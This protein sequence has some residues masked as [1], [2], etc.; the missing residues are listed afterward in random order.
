MLQA[1]LQATKTN[2]KCGLCRLIIS[3]YQMSF[4]FLSSSFRRHCQT[5]AKDWLLIGNKNAVEES[6]LQRHGAVRPSR[7]CSY[8]DEAWH[9]RC[10]ELLRKDPTAAFWTASCC[11]LREMTGSHASFGLSYTRQ[12]ST[13]RIQ[14]ASSS[15][16][17]FK[18]QTGLD[19]LHRCYM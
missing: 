10:A 5:P 2:L 18:L 4:M 7:R 15:E 8:P 12:A 9:L 6:L 3:P 19:I 17:R 1:M 11:I 14:E 13:K 16:P